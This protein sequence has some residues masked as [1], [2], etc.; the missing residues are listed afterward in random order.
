MADNL[1]I[2][3][4][5]VVP[6]HNEAENLEEFVMSFWAK[7][8]RLQPTIVEIHL[9]ENGSTDN[10][11]EV[12]QRIESEL[13]HVVTAHKIDTPSYGAA[14]KRGML[15]ASGDVV[16]ILECDVMDVEFLSTSMAI[17]R[18][19]RADFVVASKRHPLS[20]DQ[21][22]FKRRALTYFFNLWLKMYFS[23]PGT[24]T[25]GLKT[26]RSSAAK[27]L[28]ELSITGGEIFQT[29]ITL[30]AYRMGFTVLEVPV[31]IEEHRNTKVSVIQRLPKVTKMITELRR[32]LSRFPAH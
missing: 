27:S 19:G 16:S 11:Y 12:C 4:S 14:I 23:F 9:V 2:G 26:I 8:G 22:P 21:R 6:V 7:L 24:D 17:I 1:R 29:E 25:H 5:V 15:A 32:S 10:T 31:C 3:C 13:P 20:L 18:Q 30:L 28:C